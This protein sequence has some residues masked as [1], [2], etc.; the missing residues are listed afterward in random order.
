MK[1]YSLSGAS[2]TGKSTSAVAF[3]HTH[4]LDA[5]IDDGL[6]IVRGKRVAGTS[7]KFE[8]N[9]VT[10]VRR[11]IFN[12][13]AH[14]EEVKAALAKY[15][16][17]SILVIGTSDKMTRTIAQALELGEIDRYFYV[18]DIRSE[19]EIRR[20][21]FVRET[22]GKHVMPVSSDQVSQN[23]FKKL[24]KKG[25]DI[26]SP[27]RVKIGETTIV[28][29]DFH[30]QTVNVHKRVYPQ[31]V[32]YI[33]ENHPHI[34]RVEQ[35]KVLTTSEFVVELKL[36]YQAPVR[37]NLPADITALQQKLQQAMLTTFG[38]TADT[39]N[40]KVGKIE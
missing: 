37:Y 14:A 20:A 7:A 13:R 23:F 8:K 35:L 16:V 39:I 32:R 15:E 10:A 11:A 1:V 22:E 26:F 24:I 40:C 2:G 38:F 9:T 5:M 21:K 33:A 31:L 17:D 30:Q 34:A 6:L 36:I 27:K 18:T 25:W 4:K 19:N 28:H 12:E 3:A 29:P